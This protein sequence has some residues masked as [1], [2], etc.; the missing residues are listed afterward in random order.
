[1]TSAESL[2]REAIAHVE[3]RRFAEAAAACDQ[4]L[5]I[6]PQHPDTHNLRGLVLLRSGKAK[7]A[8]SCFM[9]AIKLSPTMVSAYLNAGLCNIELDQPEAAAK[10][11]RDALIAQPSAAEAHFQLGL[12]ALKRFKIAE[13]A[14]HCREA[15]AL[16]PAHPFAHA[17]LGEALVLLGRFDEAQTA[18]EHAI[19]VNPRVLSAYDNLGMLA[20]NEGRADEAIALFEKSLAID[21]D[22]TGSRFNRAVTWLRRGDL[23]RGFVDYEARWR[24][25]RTQQ[26]TKLRPFTQPQWRGESLHAQKILLWGE[27]G[28]GDEVRLS[29]LANDVVSKGASVALECDKRLVDVFARSFPG[30]QVIPRRETPDRA[31]SDPAITFHC[32]LETA[33]SFLRPTLDQ[34]PAPRAYLTPDAER[35]TEFRSRLKVQANGRPIIGLSWG[36]YNPQLSNGK[37]SALADWQA[38]LMRE[39]ILVVRL[40][41]VSRDVDTANLSQDG[42]ALL[43]KLTQ[44]PDLD[45]IQDIDGQTALIAACDMVLTVSNTTAHLAGA[46][47]VPTWVLL[48]YGHFQPWYWFKNR[49][50]SVWY[51][52]VRLYRPTKFG[53]WPLL[54]EAANRDLDGWLAKF[55]TP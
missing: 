4:I 39:D 8:L 52:N 25:A 30:V 24:L 1:M 45:L 41:K 50:D 10:S 40:Q 2:Y 7:Q 12:L 23:T 21:P 37:T 19:A 43:G 18:L 5:K 33:L 54:I 3:A 28:V 9:R 13:S 49:S 17:L 11:F 47:G 22:F 44:I 55:R 20:E 16:E 53:D 32:P 51:P 29:A 27:Q 31:T 35:T 15:T 14:Q 34:F 36:S 6:H 38:V 46:L 48:P 42:K 26:S